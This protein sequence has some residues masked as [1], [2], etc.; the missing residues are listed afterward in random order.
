MST[1]RF[2]LPLAALL[3]S[4]MSTLMAQGPVRRLTQEEAF[5]AAVTKPQ[6]EYPSVARQLR[7]QG[8]VELE[9]SID[10]AGAVDNVKVMTGNAALTGSAVS[11]LKRWRF[12]PILADGKPVRAVAVLSFAF[13]L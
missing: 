5:K 4:A 13:K 2:G 7:I 9:V 10:T 12:E 6:P 3:I 11:T 1:Q 8:Q